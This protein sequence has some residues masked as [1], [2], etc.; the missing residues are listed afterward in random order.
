[1]AEEAVRRFLARLVP[2]ADLAGKYK[3]SGRS[4][5]RKEEELEGLTK[6]LC[7][8]KHEYQRVSIDTAN[9]HCA[10]VMAARISE[11]EERLA[12]LRSK[13]NLTT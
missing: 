6:L 8:L 2:H 9:I 5:V 4:Q 13:E 10:G 7:W 11:T 1:M 12:E 3:I